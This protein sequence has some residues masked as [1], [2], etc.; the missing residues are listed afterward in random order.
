[1]TRGGP[2]WFRTLV[3]F[4]LLAMG[5][6]ITP[7][8][9]ASLWLFVPASVAVALLVSWRWGAWGV[10]VPVALFAACMAIVGPF[11][12]WVWWIPAA[13][14]TGAW[15]GLRE[16][17]GGPGEGQRAWMLL[18][19]LLLA[20]LLPW[21]DAY[22]T[23]VAN[24]ERL[25]REGDQQAVAFY[26]RL[27][28]GADQLQALERRT[29]DLAAIEKKVLPSAVPTLLFLWVMLLVAM[30]RG[31]ADRLARWFRWPGLSRGRLATWR[32]P[33]PAVWLLLL[34]LA[35]IVA[36]LPSWGPSA[37]TLLVNVSLAYCV[38]GIAVVQS[39]LLARGVPPSIITLTFVFVF[40]MAW[41]ALLLATICVGLSDVW[42]DYRRLEAVPEGD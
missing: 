13:A 38:Q 8:P 23:M 35:L 4:L 39:L 36:R 7:M 31:V 18:P 26:R 20:A 40:A 10:L 42:L 25:L 21:M 1:M 37:W 12:L 32:L 22:G 27:G 17:N 34:G 15:M 9:W 41:P 3:L 28:I 5:P 6:A 24:L 19:V 33:D 30:G 29:V 2:S 16:E 14:L 11:S